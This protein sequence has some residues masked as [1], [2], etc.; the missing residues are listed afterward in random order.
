MFYVLL[1]TYILFYNLLYIFLISHYM[2]LNLCDDALIFILYLMFTQF[3]YENFIVW[4]PNAIWLVYSGFPCVS[5]THQIL[6]FSQ[7]NNICS[8]WVQHE[9][10]EVGCKFLVFEISLWQIDAKIFI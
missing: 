7:C 1:F 6:T 2:A 5:E 8:D 9:Q 3:E 10:A 4:F